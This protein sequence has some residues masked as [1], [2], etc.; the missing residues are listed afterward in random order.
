MVNIIADVAGRYQ[1]LIKLVHQ[2]PEGEFIFLGDLVDRG[3]DSKRVMD[4]VMKNGHTCVLGNHEHMM[5]DFCRGGQFYGRWHPW[6]Y[7]GGDKTIDAFDPKGEKQRQQAIPIEYVEW[8]ESLPKFIERDNCLISHA[9]LNPYFEDDYTD[10]DAL[11]DDCDF[12]ANIN[13][14]AESTII[15]NR[16]EPIR[17]ESWRLQIAGHNSQWGLRKFED[18]NGLYA[19]CLDDSAQKKLTG[20]HLETMTIYQ[21]DYIKCEI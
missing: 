13:R 18:E 2:M 6:L 9:F 20:L 10:R 5:A 7:N 8:I 16:G 21:Q 1:E 14:K 15:W 3:P 12:G 11:E 17:R 19:I 4:F